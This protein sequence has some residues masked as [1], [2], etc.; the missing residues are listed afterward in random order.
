[1]VTLLSFFD[2]QG[3]GGGDGR[4]AIPR[5]ELERKQVA[6]NARGKGE[7]E[8]PP[9]S[10]LGR[11]GKKRREQREPPTLP[12]LF[13]RFS[14]QPVPCFP[15]LTIPHHITTLRLQSKTTPTLPA[16]PSLRDRFRCRHHHH[17]NIYNIHHNIHIHILTF[18]S[19]GAN[20]EC[21][22]LPLP[23]PPFSITSSDVGEFVVWMG[24]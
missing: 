7:S 14:A 15:S 10:T 8:S 18:I 17:N 24:E 12:A 19:S 2:H 6:L 9:N 4:L 13:P 20:P 1:M 16:A 11:E 21:G 23:F 5:A 22:C 3:Y